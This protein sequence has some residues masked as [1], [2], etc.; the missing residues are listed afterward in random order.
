[1]TDSKSIL[2]LVGTKAQ[3]IKTAPILR[4]LDLRDVPYRLVYTGQHS[5]TFD[6]LESAFGVQPASEVMVPDFE[7]DTRAGFLHWSASFWKA[8]LACIVRRRW[9]DAPLGLVH[10]D[11][12]STLFSA[13]ALRLAGVPV[14]HI[15]AGLRSPQLLTPFP[16]E[17]IRRM[18]SRLA[19]HHFAPNELAVA[20]L[21]KAKGMV[22]NTKGNT[23][24]DA[25]RMALLKM[26][27][28]PTNGGAGGY[29]VVSMHRTENLGSRDDLDLILEEVVSAAQ[30]IP[31]RF[32]LHPVTR[33]RLAATGWEPRLRSSPNIE[34]MNRLNY[35]EFVQLLVGAKF[36]W[37][38]GGSNQEEAAML[39]I[40]TLL[41]RRTTERDDGLDDTV[42][43]SGLDRSAM[44]EF[45]SRHADSI[46]AI[47]AVVGG[48][49][50]ALIAD[51]LAA[52][53][54]EIGRSRARVV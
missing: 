20:N 40:P 2:V 5:E 52:Q 47:R 21:R 31:V 33:K 25:L 51:A 43:L 44:R 16:E 53:A 4:E 37:T 18:V 46:W 7:A 42:V 1:M 26:G 22:T 54:R 9:R 48:S 36:L 10:G 6:L 27:E 29:A 28:L 13:L 35:P 30:V 41:L 3:F 11:T 38:D 17:A 15:E 49:P 45:S 12:A 24:R 14:V 32:V 39:G 23:L 19:R 50:S 8:A 34:L